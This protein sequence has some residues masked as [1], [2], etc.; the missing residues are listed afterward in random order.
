MESCGGKQERTG[1]SDQSQ[2]HVA[3]WFESAI[4]P[5]QFKRTS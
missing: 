3:K 5:L 2:Q 1:G 4:L